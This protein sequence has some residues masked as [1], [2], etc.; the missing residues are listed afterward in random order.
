MRVR[1]LSKLGRR[2]ERGSSHDEGLLSQGADRPCASAAG[3]LSFSPEA[4]ELF[5]NRAI[6][7]MVLEVRGAD[8]SN[9]LIQPRSRIKEEILS[10]SALTTEP[11]NRT[12]LYSI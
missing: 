3:S 5:V 12:W 2:K 8:A 4:A 1:S 7:L 11:E 9:W 6:R 10:S